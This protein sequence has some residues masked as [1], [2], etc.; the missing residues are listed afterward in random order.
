MTFKHQH[1]QPSR[2]TEE[3]DNLIDEL[4]D[5]LLKVREL[6]IKI[7]ETAKK[8]GLGND[9]IDVM[10]HERYLDGLKKKLIMVDSFHQTLL[11]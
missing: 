5:I 1:Q 2:T 10:I 11:K 6:L 4:K 8:E 3:L 9:E 7:D